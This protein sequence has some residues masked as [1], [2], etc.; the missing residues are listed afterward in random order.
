[1]TITNQ[2]NEQ[3]LI[4]RTGV[5]DL[6]PGINQ[7]SVDRLTFTQIVYNTSSQGEYIRS[8]HQLS[9]GIFTHCI[10]LIPVAGVEEG[11]V[12]CQDI[13]S[14]GNESLYLVYPGDKDTIVTTSPVLFWTHSEPF[15]ALG[16][17]EHF[18]L[19]F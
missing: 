7:I 2:K 3:L 15:S 5:I 6:K 19:L 10:K 1:A 14:A 18:R 9:S 4:V 8:K 16:E 11:D 12:Y 17:G 13:E